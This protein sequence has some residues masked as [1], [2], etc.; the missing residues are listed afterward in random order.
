MFEKSKLWRATVMAGVLV[1]M[2]VGTVYAYINFKT[3]GPDRWAN[4]GYEWDVSAD[5]GSGNAVCIQWSTN[6][7]SS[8]DRAECSWVGPASDAWECVIP[9]NYSSATV[10][11]Q[12]YKDVD[13]DNCTV[14]SDEWEWTDQFSFDTGP[15][16]LT[17]VSFTTTSTLLDVIPWLAGAVI[18]LGGGVLVWRRKGG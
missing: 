4:P 8:W 14:D 6:G 3:D 13:T 2:L 16:A 10:M 12:F 15:N 11:Y 17:L 1:L 7:G 9:N 18:A 5:A